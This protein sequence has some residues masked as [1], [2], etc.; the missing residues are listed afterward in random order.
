VSDL[1]YSARADRVRKRKSLTPQTAIRTLDD[2][3]LFGLD[4]MRDCPEWTGKR[5]KRFPDLLVGW[6]SGIVCRVCYKV[7]HNKRLTDRRERVIWE[8]F[9][10]E[11]WSR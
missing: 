11:R 9:L 3:F 10:K 7:R 2:G 4:I 5:C 6:G 1:E 8:A